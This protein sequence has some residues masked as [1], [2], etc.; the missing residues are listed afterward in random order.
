[1][2]LIFAMKVFNIGLPKTGTS[3]L[4]EALIILGYRSLHNPLDLRMA[5]YRQGVYRYARDD[6]DAITNF[7]E[8]FYPQL[9][10]NYPGS[11]FILTVRDRDAWLKSTEKWY[12]QPPMYPPRDNQS[13][14]ETFG[15]ITFSYERFAYLYEHHT[16][17]VKRYFEHRPDDLLISE[18]GQDEPWLDICQFLDKP[19]PNQPYPHSNNRAGKFHRAARLRRQLATWVRYGGR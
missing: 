12:S 10:Q 13:R 18:V 7:G 19:V 6:W 1:M 14:L 17:G 5:S 9:D 8:H 11:K 2:N 4:N 16:E 3:S 15:C